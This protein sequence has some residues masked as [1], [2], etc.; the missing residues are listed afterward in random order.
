MLCI[1]DC[2]ATKE[3]SLARPDLH[4]Y[5]NVCLLQMDK[6]MSTSFQDKAANYLFEDQRGRF[7]NVTLFLK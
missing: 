3:I 1:N 2:L 4:W 7:P 6:L 5:D